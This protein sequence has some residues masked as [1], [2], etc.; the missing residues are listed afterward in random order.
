MTRSDRRFPTFA[1]DRSSP[2]G[3]P[4]PLLGFLVVAACVVPLVLSGCAGSYDETAISPGYASPGDAT[5]VSW[6]YDDLRPYG[7][8]F[9]HGAY[10]WCWT[11]YDMDPYWRPYS[12]GQWVYTDYGWTWLSDEPWGWATFHYGRWAFDQVFGWVWIPGPV[13]GPAWVSWRASDSWIGWAPLPPQAEWHPN[14]GVRYRHDPPYEYWSFVPRER[15]LAYE[16]S[17]D[18][19]SAARNEPLLRGTREL[20]SI[21]VRDGRPLNRGP[22]LRDVET[23]TGELVE[24]RSIV[25]ASSPTGGGTVRGREVEMYRPRG[26]ERRT[27]VDRSQVERARED[28]P[29]DQVREVRAREE[30]ELERRAAEERE[31]M[32]IRHREESNG[33]AGENDQVRQRQREESRRL[34]EITRQRQ[35]VIEERTRRRIVPPENAREGSRERTR[36]S[37]SSRSSSS[38]RSGGEEQPRK[39][40]GGG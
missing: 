5:T 33:R 11:P 7:S 25:D 12:L 2:R 17:D 9:E 40:G 39:R 31:R 22:D 14:R 28:L 37:G 27:S 8:W 19:V 34:E 4:W 30:R 6:F 38:G 16:L 18:I 10:G 24:R 1:R 3:L 23:A 32:E 35:R 13:W 15:F 20:E 36:E 26:D 29:D 21:A